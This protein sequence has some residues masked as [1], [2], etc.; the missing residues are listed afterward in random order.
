M[1]IKNAITWLFLIG[2]LI[3]VIFQKTRDNKKEIEKTQTEKVTKRV[4][5][6]IKKTKLTT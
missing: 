1:K 2:I 3:T 6:E 5:P 4:T